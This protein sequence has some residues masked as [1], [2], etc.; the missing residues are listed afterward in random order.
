MAGLHQSVPDNIDV[1][2][3]AEF[4]IY[5]TPRPVQM[6]RILADELENVWVNETN[7]IP[8]MSHMSPVVFNRRAGPHGHDFVRFPEEM[9]GPFCYGG[10]IL[11]V[12]MGAGFTLK[13]ANES[14]QPLKLMV[15]KEVYLEEG[16]IGI[17]GARLARRPVP[18]RPPKVKPPKRRKRG[19]EE[20]VPKFSLAMGCV[21][22]G[23]D[24]G[25]MMEALR[26]YYGR[27]ERLRREGLEGLYYEGA[28]GQ[29]AARDK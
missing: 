14:A 19:P 4:G 17:D 23:A 20:F 12:L 9:N 2:L 1:L 10:A 3:Q 25:G 8:Q 27:A 7:Y 5:E 21:D 15:P 11:R 26:R 29:R 16:D 6:D 28:F 22:N 24:L 18:L 13:W